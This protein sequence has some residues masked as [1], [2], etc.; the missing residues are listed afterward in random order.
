M[1]DG[2]DKAVS[3]LWDYMQLKQPVKAADLIIVLGS[4]DDRVAAYAAELLRRGIAERCIVTGGSAHH[5]DFLKTK[6]AE[7]TEAEHFANMMKIAGV[8]ESLLFIEDL[9]TNTGENAMF[10]YELVKSM[11]SDVKSVLLVTKPYMERRALATFEAQWPNKSAAIRVSSQSGSINEYCNDDQKYDVVVNIMVGD[12]Q[13]IVEY[14]KLGLQI[15]QPLAEQQL[16]AFEVLVAA[17]FT[18]HLLS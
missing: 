14:P 8:D 5:H 15:E 6:W 16:Q 3:V 4:R 10:S 18:K 13:R 11:E 7:A 12:F 17:G 2:V 9:A 1:S